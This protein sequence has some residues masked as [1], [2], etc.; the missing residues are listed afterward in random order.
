MER[1]TTIETEEKQRR[2][3]QNERNAVF[4]TIKWRFE[5]C[6]Q[7]AIASNGTNIFIGKVNVCERHWFAVF[8]QFARRF[9]FFTKYWLFS[10][11][12]VPAFPSTPSLFA[13]I[14]CC[15]LGGWVYVHSNFN[16]KRFLFGKRLILFEKL[17]KCFSF[18]VL[19]NFR[20]FSK[21]RKKRFSPVSVM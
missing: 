12:V 7:R 4:N 15:R 6:R 13:P 16:S 21:E 11:V 8:T 5:R 2:V 17:N 20:Y 3:Q 19:W 18:Y 10:F 14:E 9:N 1:K